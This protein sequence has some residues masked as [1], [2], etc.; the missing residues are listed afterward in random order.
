MVSEREEELMS[1]WNMLLDNGKHIKV[2]QSDLSNFKNT[3][4]ENNDLKRRISDLFLLDM[5]VMNVEFGIIPQEILQSIYDLENNGNGSL[6]KPAQ[7]F[8][9]PPLKGLRYKH[10]FSAR[11]I[12]HNITSELG[13]NGLR[14]IVFPELMPNKGG[15]VT[16]EMIENIARRIAEE[17]LEK[18]AKKGELTGE[19]IIYL[20]RKD[21]NYYLTIAGH[22]F[23][24][25][26]IFD[27]I[28]ANCPRDFPDLKDWLT[29]TPP[30]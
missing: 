27:K 8:K 28:I 16:S 30:D 17:P 29:Q 3:Y 6:T 10:F 12:A 24:D 19:W 22:D 25:Q 15:T 21:G 9:K 2:S 7:A 18:R 26:R 5:Y 1:S 13:K 20:P 4:I 23:G 14:S 11:F